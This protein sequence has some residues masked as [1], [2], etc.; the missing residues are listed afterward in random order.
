MIN[1][2]VSS[3]RTPPTASSHHIFCPSLNGLKLPQCDL[4]YVMPRMNHNRLI[5]ETEGSSKWAGLLAG[6]P[7]GSEQSFFQ[8]LKQIGYKGV[9]NWP[10]SIL[11]DGYLRQAISSI[12]ISP[13]S[14]YLFLQRAKL[15]GFEVMAFFKSL[16]Q[17]KIAV[18]AGLDKLILHP[19]ILD[20]EPTSN[21]MLLGSLQRIIDSLKTQNSSLTILIYT[22]DWHQKMLALNSLDTD[23]SVTCELAQ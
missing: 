18:D 4:A 9:V 7:F 16:D 5:R 20:H 23:G 1:F 12:P 14:E 19:G 10:S 17:G 8:S 11:L 3:S 22:S 6:D 2:S 13:S 15:A 21:S